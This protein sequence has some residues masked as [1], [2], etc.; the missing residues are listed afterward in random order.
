MA[1]HS[2]TNT[3]PIQLNDATYDML[4]ILVEKVFPAMGLFYAALAFIWGWGYG[5]EVTGSFAAATTFGGVLLTL[6]RKGYEPD[7]GVPKGGFDG[8][9][10][11]GTGEEGAPILTFKLDPAKV[12]DVLN[13][14]VVTFKGFDPTA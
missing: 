8:E 13:K 3:G 5:V 1:D 7:P 4:R 2:A 14:K 9:I 10:I 6:S 12:E 11:S